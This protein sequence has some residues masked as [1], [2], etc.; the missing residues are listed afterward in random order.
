[1]RN[2]HENAFGELVQLRRAQVFDSL[3]SDQ[4]DKQLCL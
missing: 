3:R 4:N 1:M 2:L